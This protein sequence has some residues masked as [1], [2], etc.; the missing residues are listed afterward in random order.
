MHDIPFHIYAMREPDYVM[1]LVS[2]YGT[3]ELQA[4][5]CT[6]R[7]YE[8]SQKDTVTTIFCYP[9]VVSN[10][11]KFRHTMDDHNTR[12]H[13]PISLEYFLDT[14][15]WPHFL[16]LFLLAIS[17]VNTNLIEAYCTENSTPTAQL[18]FRKLLVTLSELQGNILRIHA[19]KCIEKLE[20][21]VYIPEASFDTKKLRFEL[22]RGR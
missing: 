14:K 18:E 17:E 10:C 16:F 12:R 2:I 1:K 8:D 5:H 19:L 4:D 6:K 21:I 22:S 7:I 11:F 13:A 20:P 3:N 9:E 15:H